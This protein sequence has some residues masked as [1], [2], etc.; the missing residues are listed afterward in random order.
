MELP[1]RKKHSLCLEFVDST[2]GDWLFGGDVLVTDE[3][4]P[5]F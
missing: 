1:T 3:S 2:S 4:I 5:S